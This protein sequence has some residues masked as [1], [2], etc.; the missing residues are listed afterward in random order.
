[1]L[2]WLACNLVRVLAWMVCRLPLGLSVRVGEAVGWMVSWLVPSRIRIGCWNIKAA[3]GDR[4][5]PGEPK[6]IIRRLFM[7]LGAGFVEMLRL[8]AMDAAYAKRYLTIPG[9]E[10]FDRA[11][12][13]RPLILLSGH[14]GNWE[15][16]SIA[17]TYVKGHPLTAVARMQNTFPKLYELLVSY[18]EAK[19]CTIV[20]KGSTM[21]HVLRALDN[22]QPVAIVADQASRRGIFV[23]FLGRP[24]LFATGPFELARMRNAVLLF[25]FTH[26]L[27]GPH[28]RLVVEPPVE[29][30]PGD[31]DA[32][33]RFGVE[34]FAAAL[35]RHITEDP[36]QWLW[37]H[38]RWK[39]TPAR[40]V[41]VLSDGKL[42]HLKQSLAVVQ[43]LKEQSD[44]VQERVIEVRYRSRLGRVLALAHAAMPWIPGRWSALRLALESSCYARLANAYANIVVSCGS[45]TAPVNVLMS[46]ESRAKSVVIMNPAPLPVSRFSLA[47]VPVHDRPKSRANLV[48]TLGALSVTP[49]GALAAARERLKSHPRFRAAGVSGPE[50]A[51]LLGGDASDYQVTVPFVEALMHQ[52]LGLCEAWHGSCLVTTSRRTAP[53]VEQWLADQLATHPRCS[54][55]LLASR[56]QLDG[57]L[58]GMFG[59]AKAIVVTADSISMVSEA[60]AS[61]RPV[62]VIEPPLK[63]AAKRAAKSQR[64]LDALAQGQYIHRTSLP[65]MRQAIRRSL[66]D[67]Q[68][69][70]RLE[71]YAAVRNAVKRL[72]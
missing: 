57:T 7:N 11:V 65:Q 6:R 4:L 54:L 8:P 64:Y 51:V 45:S 27:R 23:N 22:R 14:F 21:R 36:G 37:L 9:H 39:Y 62:F 53:D 48:P 20:H 16:C 26:R 18:R 68:A 19:G 61:G 58:E 10:H 40:R 41:L 3:L 70:R 28:H 66:V 29:L 31:P 1:M 42:G 50:I 56:D 32:A 63:P 47:F 34:R 35:E 5:A 38:K 2:D 43:A 49:N 69:T 55:L 25:V 67:G 71:T 12:N 30:P 60:C 72:L 46:A 15:L 24:A 17:A 59:C 33:I 52:V 13:S 44:G